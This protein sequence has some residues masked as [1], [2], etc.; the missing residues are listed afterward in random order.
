MG[1]GASKPQETPRGKE[2]VPPL[3]K[4]EPKAQSEEQLIEEVLDQIE[5]RPEE[6]DIEQVLEKVPDGDKFVDTELETGIDKL[7]TPVTERNY[8]PP[9][10]PHE[11]HRV[12]IIERGYGKTRIEDIDVGATDTPY[13]YKSFEGDPNLWYNMFVNH[14]APTYEALLEDLTSDLHTDKEKVIAITAWISQQNIGRRKDVGTAQDS[15][16]RGYIKLMQSGQGTFAAFFAILCRTV[17]IPCVIVQGYSKPASYE[18]GELDDVTLKSF[19]NSWNVVHC[20]GAWCIINPLLVCR[21]LVKLKNSGYMVAKSNWEVTSA[22]RTSAG[23]LSSP[24]NGYFMFTNPLEFVQ[25]FIPV[26]EQE[27]WQLLLEPSTFEKYKRD[28]FTT[29]EFYKQNLSLGKNNTSCILESSNGICNIEIV[30][31]SGRSDRFLATFDIESKSN[32]VGKTTDL[33]SGYMNSYQGQQYM[34]TENRDRYEHSENDDTGLTTQSSGNNV[35]DNVSM[36]DLHRYVIMSRFGGYSKG[37]VFEIRFPKEGSYIFSVFGGDRKIWNEDPPLLCSFMLICKEVNTTIPKPLIES[38]LFGW[39]PGP[40]T[41][42]A[43]FLMPSHETGIVKLAKD[44]EAYIHFQVISK[45]YIFVAM[46]QKKHSKEEMYNCFSFEEVRFEQTDRRELI[47]IATVPKDEMEYTLRVATSDHVNGDDKDVICNYLLS[48]TTEVKREYDCIG[49]RCDRTE[50][51][52]VMTPTRDPLVEYVVNKPK[53]KETRRELRKIHVSL[54]LTLLKDCIHRAEM[55]HMDPNDEDVLRVKRRIQFLETTAIL[56]EARERNN[57]GFSKKALKKI[58]SSPFAGILRSDM[59][60]VKKMMQKQEERGWRH[61]VPPL[62]PDNL[63]QIVRMQHPNQEVQN[64]M[65]AICH[66]LGE[67]PKEPKE[68]DK[69]LT[70]RSERGLYDSSWCLIVGISSWYLKI[71]QMPLFYEDILTSWN[72]FCNSDNL[73]PQPKLFKESLWYNDNIKIN[74]QTDIINENGTF[75]LPNE[76]ENKFS[77]KLKICNSKKLERAFGQNMSVLPLVKHRS[78]F[79]ITTKY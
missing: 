59:E 22:N 53:Q 66:L 1:G 57:V 34:E 71:Y 37:I 28:V 44:E 63:A 42:K 9:T 30:V 36:D 19:T 2:N 24:F 62:H 25:R 51:H 10:G 4:E 75:L 41:R 76:I 73:A 61:E 7:E 45:K 21:S 54:D 3:E 56:K 40:M 69:S 38:G 16:P 23:V 68:K 12:R 70:S 6:P 29:P 11:K 32:E 49:A 31:P 15:T 60:Y 58:E 14:K 55:F 33:D 39:G 13:T 48:T 27:P 77:L 26:P 8:P 79:L 50:V 43:G 74:K 64:V 17:G 47:I 65:N 46:P 52:K 5:D 67:R 35:I 20:D 18:V 78:P 72:E